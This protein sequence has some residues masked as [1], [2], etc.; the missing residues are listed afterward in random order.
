MALGATAA[1]P[2]LL[3]VIDKLADR[4]EALLVRARPLASQTRDL[5][6]ALE[7]GVIQRLAESLLRRLRRRDP[8]SQKVHHSKGE[9][10]LIAL[11]GAGRTLGERLAPR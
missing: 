6:L 2:A 7:I 10:A 3:G 5:G 11:L 4:T 9:A 1:G 8:L